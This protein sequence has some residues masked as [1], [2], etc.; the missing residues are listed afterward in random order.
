MIAKLKALIWKKYITLTAGGH[1]DM[2]N[3]T[4]NITISSNIATFSYV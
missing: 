4:G 1:S 2:R 3:T